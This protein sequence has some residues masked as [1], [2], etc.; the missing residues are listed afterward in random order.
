[1]KRAFGNVIVLL[2][3]S[4]LKKQSVFYHLFFNMK[5]LVYLFI[6]L[7]LAAC[8]APTVAPVKV[9]PSSK[10]ISYLHDVKPILDKRCVVCHSCYNSPCQAK[11]S[12]FEG[13]D[14]G[15][16]KLAVYDASRLSA[17]SPTR[18]F[19]DATTTSEWR[20][21]GFFTLTQTQESNM[22]SND[23]IMIHLLYNKKMHPQIIGE[24]DPEN[25]KLTCPRNKEELEEYLDDKPNHG[26]PYGLP[27]LK[28]SEYKTVASWLAQGAKGPT[29]KEQKTLQT[30]SRNAQ[31][32]IQKWEHFLNKQDAKHQVTARYLYEHLYLAHIY[33]PS[34][35]G[36]Y[37]S[38]IRSITPA[39]KK[40]QIIATTRVF[41]NP[42]AAKFYYRLEKIHSTIVHKTHMTFKFDDAVLARFRELFIQSKWDEKPH[43][44]DYDVKTS[45]NPILEFA[46]IPVRSRYQFLLDNSQ[47]IITN[48]IRGPV[49]RGQ[50]ALNVIQ[51]H[52]WVMF[53]DPDYDIGVL[54]PTFLKQEAENLTLPIAD[55][56]NPIME[57]LSNA[58][59]KKY[60]NYYRDKR[61]VMKEE[62]PNGVSYNSIWKGNRAS[63]APILTIYRH[64][65]SASVSKGV[66]GEEPKTMWVID[67]AQFERI[68]YTLV[69]GYDVFGNVSHQ[70]NI[71][72]YMDYLRLEGELNFLDYMPRDKR[73][74]MFL[75]WYLNDDSFSDR[76]TNLIKNLPDHIS[77]TTKHPKNEFIEYIVKK[78]IL[79][80]TGIAFDGVNYAKPYAAD[81]KMP[82]NFK[83]LDDYTQ[84]IRSITRSGNNF[85]R[86]M[87]DHR[88]NLIFVRVEMP[89]GI[90]LT[91]YLV[92]NRWH[93]NVNSMF[94]EEDT[95]NH[96]KDTMD[97]LKR[98]V[99]SY[100]N[101]FAFIKFK[102]LPE[103]LKLI[104]DYDESD[105][106][107]AKLRRFFISRSD[108]NFWKSYDWFQ[109]HYNKEEPIRGGLYD[110]NR[111]S[112]KSWS[113]K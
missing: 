43:V 12:S 21:K 38:L 32:E 60:E 106:D 46:Q 19:V 36:E 79:K 103:F 24:Y 7:F 97:I 65:D 92:I 34:A 81:V 69:A 33:F 48:F 94:F 93:D 52:F 98:S 64:F 109:K 78:Y 5:L 39:P 86:Y 2:I 26:M 37:Y 90:F 47:Y 40:P 87:T 44:M 20:K 15:A 55:I 107:N 73:I 96:K 16:S 111:Y 50:I 17:A 83:T 51:D 56:N 76:D 35:K 58:Y 1:M 10:K 112:R 104:K 59:R 29:T 45:T 49:C 25:D 9:E 82:K 99:G 101:A 72:R 88:A 105:E 14:R 85:V 11:F 70:A 66:L 61:R 68:Y 4:I 75:S 100:P 22:T 42:N 108:K 71:R 84:A 102:D 6:V 74:P 53:R 95:L 113:S 91:R 67:Y 30:P 3:L 23:S 77:Y 110:L 57:V 41:D 8:S 27:A 62:F 13:I 89:D 54:N 18:L 28:E 80:S 31:K 63:D